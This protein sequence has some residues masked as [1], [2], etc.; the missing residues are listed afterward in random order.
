MQAYSSL[1]ITQLHCHVLDFLLQ[2]RFH[3]FLLTCKNTKAKVP[4]ILTVFTLTPIFWIIS[5]VLE[6][7]QKVIGST[8]LLLQRIRA[9][10]IYFHL[11]FPNWIYRYSCIVSHCALIVY[12][13]FISAFVFLIG[14]GFCLIDCVANIFIQYVSMQIDR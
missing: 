5:R 2:S 11:T 9:L 12:M 6:R 8:L 7:T 14:I 13:D 1:S 10:K 4:D 3:I